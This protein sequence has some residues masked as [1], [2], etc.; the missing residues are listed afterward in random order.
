M[1]ADARTLDHDD[2]TADCLG[3]VAGEGAIGQVTAVRLGSN[4]AWGEKDDLE[5]V[6]LLTVELVHKRC[7]YRRARSLPVG[8]V[9]PVA[10]LKGAQFRG[11]V[12]NELF[13]E[14]GL[15]FGKQSLVVF[16]SQRGL[17]GLESQMGLSRC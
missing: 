11:I 8:G 17:D 9:P 4:F 2:G 13:E 7:L 5:A 16:G 1:V 14:P 10:L 12:V 3:D 15:A 6:S